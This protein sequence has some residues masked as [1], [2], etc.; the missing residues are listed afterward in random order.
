LKFR[1]NAN[2]YLAENRL[3][4]MSVS[5][6]ILSAFISAMFNVAPTFNFADEQQI[7][8]L[9][10]QSYE[11]EQ[12]RQFWESGNPLV[13]P[14]CQRLHT[15]ECGPLRC[16]SRC[17]SGKYSFRELEE[18]EAR[19]LSPGQPNETKERLRI[20]VNETDTRAGIQNYSQMF[21]IEGGNKNGA[22]LRE[23]FS[24][25]S[26]G[27]RGEQRG[28]SLFGDRGIISQTWKYLR[29]ALNRSADLIQMLMAAVT[30]LFARNRQLE[31]QRAE[32][33]QEFNTRLFNQSQEFRAQLNAK[34]MEKVQ[35]EAHA[36]QAHEYAKRAGLIVRSMSGEK[37]SKLMQR[38]KYA[39]KSGMLM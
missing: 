22:T 17:C 31:A 5:F 6:L 36:F 11:I 28:N 24:I 19:L 27:E 30:Q 21:G 7:L 23:V 20:D 16:S 32:L 34:E 1:S 25:R 4:A 39:L 12:D 38:M 15:A 18:F 33:I 10:R 13:V 37:P 9:Q 2:A 3:S 14:F 26:R 8:N 29:L 35:A